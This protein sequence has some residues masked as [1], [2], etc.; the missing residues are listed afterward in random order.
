MSWKLACPAC[1]QPIRPRQPTLGRPARCPRCLHRFVIPERPAELFS[2]PSVFPSASLPSISSPI[3][4]LNKLVQRFW[5][6]LIIVLCITIL[7]VLVVL[8]GWRL[9][10]VSPA[11][12]SPPS[13]KMNHA[14]NLVPGLAIGSPIIKRVEPDHPDAL[15][16]SADL[17]RKIDLPPGDKRK[18][19]AVL[20]PFITFVSAPQ[21][22]LFFVATDE[23][24]LLSYS[25][26]DFSLK[27]RVFLDGPA[28]YLALDEKNGQLYAAV[29]R[30][31]RIKVNRLGERENL[32]ADLFRYDV[33]EL[34]AGRFPP[35]NRLL[36]ADRLEL[37]LSIASFHLAPDGRLLYLMAQ[38]AREL[39]FLRVATGRLS[40]E[41]QSRQMING[42]A[43]LTMSPDGAMLF[44]MN[45]GLICSLDPQTW[46]TGYQVFVG[47][48]GMN[49]I[50]LDARRVL[51]LDRR[52]ALNASI[53]DLPS[54]AALAR[55]ELPLEGRPYLACSPRTEQLFIATSAV[56][57]GAVWQ[58]DYAGERR[59]NPVTVGAAASDRNRL[60][61]GPIFL[62]SDGRYLM[63]GNGVVLPVQPADMN[64]S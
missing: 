48:T 40:I 52:P 35:T 21:N 37:G 57:S 39:S 22:G 41:Q 19:V 28:C 23:G 14:N 53:V 12:G 46:K 42:L 43:G 45:G 36:P 50:A 6:P 17:L 34:L 60:L 4:S 59:Q 20:S 16:V 8:V 54:R 32:I 9:W 58:L 24:E 63:F 30:G 13:Q 29:S 47:L 64:K 31:V 38:E 55:W 26:T 27:G 11:V 2:P 49:P 62:S 10:S 7:P 5:R 61:R 15:I 18:A 1:D 56:L 51:F 44:T 25:A 33:R 3:S